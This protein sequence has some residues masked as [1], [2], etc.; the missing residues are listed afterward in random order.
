M[1]EGLLSYSQKLNDYEKNW[2]FVKLV[3]LIK[4]S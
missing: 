1:I 3:N 2:S 4:V